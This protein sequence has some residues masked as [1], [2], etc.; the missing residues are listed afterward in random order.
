M[1]LIDTPELRARRLAAYQAGLYTVGRMAF[2]GYTGFWS[3]H[4]WMNAVSFNDPT[5][6]G[7]LPRGN[8]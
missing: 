2:A 5:L 3:T 4:D 1:N 7:I 8:Q 6:T